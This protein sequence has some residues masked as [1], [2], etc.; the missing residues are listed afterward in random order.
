MQ[1]H[2]LVDQLFRLVLPFGGVPVES[3]SHESRA[4][5]RVAQHQIVVQGVD[6]RSDA[7]DEPWVGACHQHAKVL[8]L[9]MYIC[10]VVRHEHIQSPEELRKVPSGPIDFRL[11]QKSR[12]VAVLKIECLLVVRQGHGVLVLGHGMVAE[13]GQHIRRGKFFVVVLKGLERLQRLVLP[14]QYVVFCGGHILALAEDRLNLI[15]CAKGFVVL[16]LLEVE[17]DQSEVEVVL[18]RE[19]LQQCLVGSDRQVILSCQ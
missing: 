7:L 6:L 15:Q 5:G 2:V 13:L 8:C 10:L 11:S 19:I 18:F 14:Q 4:V 16:V 17:I 3:R 12:H 1:G 9:G